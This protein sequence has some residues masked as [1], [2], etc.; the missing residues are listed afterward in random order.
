MNLNEK[1]IKLQYKAKK[2]IEKMALKV[3]AE[4]DIEKAFSIAEW[5]ARF[6][7]MNSCGIYR[8]DD[9]EEM[10]ARRLPEPLQ[11][12]LLP[13]RQEIHIASEVYTHGGHTRLI[14][15]LLDSA[16][17]DADVLLIRGNEGRSSV[18]KTHDGGVIQLDATSNVERACQIMKHVVNYKNI[19]I[20]IHPEDI[21]SAAAL[22]R[23]RP[24]LKNSQIIFVNHADHTFSLGLASADIIFEISSYGWALRGKRGTEKI[25]SFIGIPLTP[26]QAV[27]V[28]SAKKNLIL[29]G[30][31]A[32]KF[33]PMAG[34]NFQK[35]IK[36]LLLSNK[37]LN[38]VIVGPRWQDYWWWS[39]KLQFGER[40][41]LNTKLPYKDYV[42]CLAM[43]SVYLDSYPL[44]GGTAFTEAL[45]KG[46]NVAGMAGSINGYGMADELKSQN[47]FKLNKFVQK[48]EVQHPDAMKQQ[49]TIRK[50]AVIFHSPIAV[51]QRISQTINTGK[52][53][54]LAFS[55][56]T[57]TSDPWFDLLWI[58]RAR[59][60]VPGFSNALQVTAV[61]PIL[62]TPLFKSFS[63]LH[64]QFFQL[65]LKA[66]YSLVM[67][68]K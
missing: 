62:L 65:F 50:Q 22:K 1:K 45:I 34:E 35:N 42:D 11:Q 13:T 38:A 37:A 6:L 59:I 40:L 33:K 43:C 49:E 63:L 55:A 54:P 10:L 26:R 61:I 18:F 51:R 57:S 19:F 36:F 8:F 52:M 58:K 39:L 12:N 64:V 56:V 47:I 53:H 3:D 16:D 5:I 60:T 31:D 30:G 21:V 7:V 29:S 32:Y 46:C 67:K 28:S 68:K 41:K 4:P 9:L 27:A 17:C 23:I 20:H 15:N 24:E 2:F 14:Q 44:T 66:A 48:I 25:S